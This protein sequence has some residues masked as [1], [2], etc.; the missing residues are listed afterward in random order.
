MNKHLILEAS[1]LKKSFPG[2]IEVLK[3]I[4][5][6]CQ[7][8][9]SIA[10]T[11]KSG[12]GKSTLLSILSGFSEPDSG[13]VQL[14]GHTLNLK[15]T[16][17]LDQLRSDK[18]GMIFQQFHLVSVLTARENIQVRIDGLKGQASAKKRAL[19]LLERIGLGH[20]ADHLPHQLSG[21]EQQRVAIA[22]AMVTAPQLVFADEPCGNLDFESAK[23]AEDLL[24]EEV[25]KSNSSLILI[26]HDLELA[27]RCNRTFR[28]M[29]GKLQ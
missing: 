19:E 18:I 20:R 1:D 11:G 14:F 9:E 6:Q 15:N 10:I 23:M 25:L 17:H 8:G 2:G 29:L 28:L 13:V 16:S 27:A 3:G 4:S 26:T 22:R 5:L 24:F 7:L 12:S 21:G